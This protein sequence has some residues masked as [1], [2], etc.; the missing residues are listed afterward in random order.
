MQHFFLNAI[1]FLKRISFLYRLVG[2][3]MAYFVIT[4]IAIPD[5][6]FNMASSKPVEM[7]LDEL[8][9]TP[10][11]TLPRYLKIKDAV[12]PAGSY[13]ETRKGKSN[14]LQEIYYPVYPSEDVKIP[15]SELNKEGIS[16]QPEDSKIVVDTTGKLSIVKNTD[17]I[18]AKLVIHDTHIQESDLD[19]TGKYFSSPDFTIEGKFDGSQLGSDIVKLFTDA[20]LN[21]EE[22]AILLHRG[23][24]G[25]STPT[26]TLLALMAALVGILAILT[27]IPQDTLLKFSGIGGTWEEYVAA[28]TV[29]LE[30]ITPANMGKRI[31]AYVIDY[32]ILY[33]V[34]L[35]FSGNDYA[36]VIFIGVSFIYFSACDI[37]LKGSSVGKMILKQTVTPVKLGEELTQNRILVRNL[38][39]SIFSFFPLIYLVAFANTARQTLHDMA[40][41]TTVIDK[42]SNKI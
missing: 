21:I 24:S 10:K 32:I 39:K 18:N 15:L 12:V 20:G 9:K 11:E 42:E 1:S 33:G 22:D 30:G 27:F 34:L 4:S 28:N 40:A 41:K 25:M 19:S 29:T 6:K 3:V 17:K 23:D 8:F 5:I 26:A 36:Y 35:A 13:V 7:T 16:N 14:S 37:F 38:I 2:I 31:G